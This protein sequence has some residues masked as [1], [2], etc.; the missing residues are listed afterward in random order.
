[1][2]NEIA[3]NHNAAVDPLDESNNGPAIQTWCGTTWHTE[4][5]IPKTLGQCDDELSFHF[6]MTVD[7]VLHSVISFCIEVYAWSDL[8]SQNC[9]NQH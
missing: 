7:M 4:S 6:C 3:T 1:M 9:R 5:T 8:G 2:Y